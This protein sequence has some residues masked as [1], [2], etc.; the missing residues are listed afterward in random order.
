MAKH[1]TSATT[2]GKVEA[3]QYFKIENAMKTQKSFPGNGSAFQVVGTLL[4]GR[5]KTPLATDDLLENTDGAA[6]LLPFVIC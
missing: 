3:E 1:N 2:K 5:S 6:P 4:P